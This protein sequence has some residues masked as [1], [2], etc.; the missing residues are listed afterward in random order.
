MGA[1]RSVLSVGL[2]RGLE[3]RVESSLL[4]VDPES[5]S[6][7]E[8]LGDS[9]FGLKY[10]LLDESPTRPAVLAEVTVRLPTGDETRGLGV[11]GT[12]V[13]LLGA[14]SKTLGPVNVTGNVGYTFVTRD[15]SL[16]FW[17]LAASLEY[18]FGET[19]WL[20]GEA[21]SAV[22][23]GSLRDTLILRGGGVWAVMNS[24]RLD[25]A[26]GAGLTRASPDFTVTVGLTWRLY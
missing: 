14:A 16:E 21:V 23:P 25:G 13:M 12:D 5:D 4:L 19:T 2:V 18:R 22:S 26:V 8:G 3:I 6:T 10:R 1:A 7:R 17:W 11:D 15:R 9:L 24:L 20:V